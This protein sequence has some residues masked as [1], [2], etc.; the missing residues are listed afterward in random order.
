[1]TS[2]YWGAT[3]SKVD[4]FYEELASARDSIRGENELLGDLTEYEIPVANL[5]EG[6]IGGAIPPDQ[7]P[8]GET[9]VARSRYPEIVYTEDY[10][11]DPIE[12]KVDR[13]FYRG[14]I[15]AAV[16]LGSKSYP[17]DIA[18]FVSVVTNSN[19]TPGWYMVLAIN[20]LYNRLRVNDTID[21]SIGELND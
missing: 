8:L 11:N 9:D 20:S 17:R 7:I 16:P 5:D 13:I 15:P 3:G 2:Q 6:Q 10:L 4:S 12:F 14:A 21:K 19:H 18:E 1:M